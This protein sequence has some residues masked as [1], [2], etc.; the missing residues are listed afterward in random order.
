MKFLLVSLALLGAALATPLAVPF[1]R[2][3]AVGY[4]LGGTEAKDGQVPYIV[5]LQRTTSHTCGGVIVS[6]QWIITA[7]H[8]VSGYVSG[9]ILS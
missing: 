7:A 6:D 5:S 1:N 3:G 4:I 8:C 9:L 2:T